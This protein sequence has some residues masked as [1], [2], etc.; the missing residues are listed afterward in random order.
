MYVTS[1]EL[2]NDINLTINRVD[3]IF[4][5]RLKFD[6]YIAIPCYGT[7]IIL[8][9]SFIGNDNLTLQEIDELEESLRQTVGERYF[10]NLMGTVYQKQGLD[11]TKIKSIT[12]KIDSLIDIEIIT[13]YFHKTE[14]GNDC[15]Q[16]KSLFNLTETPNIWE[17][18]V[19]EDEIL[20]LTLYSGERPAQN[21]EIKAF[22][23]ENRKIKLVFIEDDN[24]YRGLMKTAMLAITQ[25]V[26]M[27]H[28]LLDYQG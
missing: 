16:L 14:L 18:Q 6:E 3:L 11:Y 13:N 19:N 25:K 20:V 22:A 27:C 24:S 12:Q 15:S 23:G 8:R 7:N 1:Q 4:G 26:S 28:V 5:G 2:V 9:F 17:I 21:N 10:G